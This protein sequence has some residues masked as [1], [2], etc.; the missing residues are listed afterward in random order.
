MIRIG[1]HIGNVIVGDMGYA[2]SKSITAIGD[3]VNTASRLESL[4]K[5]FN[6]QLL[7]SKK[8]IEIA[9][10]DIN[11]FKQEDVEIPGRTEL[12]SVCIIN[13]ANALEL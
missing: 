1:I 12:L 10:I 4:N 7:V 5:N 2:Q 13:N 11:K 6:S 3:A 9:E 8:V